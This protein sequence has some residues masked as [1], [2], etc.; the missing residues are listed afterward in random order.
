MNYA[1][2][3]A[4]LLV[5][6]TALA[7]PAISQ[8][9]LG[10]G[11]LETAT[12]RPASIALAHEFD[13]KS[14]VNERTYRV[15]IAI[16]SSKPPA[17]GFPVIYVLD[18]DWFFGTFTEAVRLRSGVRD[19]DPAVV[20]GITY[21]RESTALTRRMYDLSPTPLP[22]DEKAIVKELPADAE[23]GGAASFYE[24]MDRE[25]KPRVAKETTIDA[26]R[27]TLFGWSLAGL[28]VL[29][30]L[31]NHPGAFQTYVAL[32]PSIW[33]NHQVILEEEQGFERRIT[34]GQVS[35]RIFI[36]VGGL[37][38]SVPQGELPPGFTRRAMERELRAAQMVGNV[39]RLGARLS[40]LK[41]ANGYRIESHVFTG[42]TH[43]SVPWPAIG[44]ILE[45]A[46][47]TRAPPSR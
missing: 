37:E 40:A 46:V 11:S 26:S 20:V 41:G 23:Y 39:E 6:S 47:P 16:P 12:S 5:L 3:N 13:F 8:D 27:S 42:Q 22:D 7:V 24:V 36:A 31:F 34:S 14:T 29:N 28:Y 38:Q 43:S 15:K 19:I 33:W 4:A 2:I 21:P 18:G 45:F 32:S 44:P 30:T 17:A 10:S 35:P 9:T 25:V 1:S